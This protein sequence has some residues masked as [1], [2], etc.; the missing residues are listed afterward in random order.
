MNRP[1]RR[2]RYLAVVLALTLT[3]CAVG[4][5][6]SLLLFPLYIFGGTDVPAEYAG[7]KEKKVVVV[8]RPI[9]SLKYRCA[10][11]DRELA[12][13]VNKL[14]RANVRK[15]E[16]VS[17]QEVDQWLDEHNEMADCTEI[18]TALGADMVVGID[19]ERFELKKSQTLYQGTANVLVRVYDCHDKGEPVFE[20]E[21]PQSIYPPNAAIQL[22]GFSEERK[23]RHKYVGFLADQI[24]RH[25]YP[26]DP[27]ADYALDAKAFN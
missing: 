7:L 20:K 17:Q 6:R 9:T 13:E 3:V 12:R 5:C 2:Y 25:F 18:G 14:L 24:G 15:I 4:G 23:F 19:L 26:H 8:C 21:L 16:V 11:V 27:H 10:T 1:F 22:H